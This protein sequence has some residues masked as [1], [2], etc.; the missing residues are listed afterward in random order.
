M[1]LQSLLPSAPSSHSIWLSLYVG[2]EWT[3]FSRC[4]KCTQFVLETCSQLCVM[5]DVFGQPS[6][7][8]FFGTLNG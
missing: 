5:Y 7:S 4:V 2:T 6:Y 3:T 8:N 1:T